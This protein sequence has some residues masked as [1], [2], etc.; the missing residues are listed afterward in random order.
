MG[1]LIPSDK[2]VTE[3]FGFVTEEDRRRWG[4]SD[5]KGQAAHHA[6][7]I[8]TQ[9]AGA[10]VT[11]MLSREEVVDQIE[12]EG[13]EPEGVDVDREARENLEALRPDTAQPHSRRVRRRAL[14]DKG[15]TAA[16]KHPRNV[17]K[18][19]D[20]PEAQDDGPAQKSAQ[21]EQARSEQNA[22]VGRKT[23]RA[24][25][26]A[27][28]RKEIDGLELVEPDGPSLAPTHPGE[29]LGLE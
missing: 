20:E 24:A 28:L 14:P 8:S 3:A 11:D 1:A 16:A 29:R 4:R 7:R 6:R 18:P 26:M 15:E 5:R 23:N 22:E 12:P 27:A 13:V 10:L 21:A 25:R 9:L 19:Q 17:D 2:D